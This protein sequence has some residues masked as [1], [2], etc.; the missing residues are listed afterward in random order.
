[1]YKIKA[2]ENLF[3]ALHTHTPTHRHSHTLTEFEQFLEIRAAAFYNVILC[4]SFCCV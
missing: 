2:N 3:N 1:M 4:Y